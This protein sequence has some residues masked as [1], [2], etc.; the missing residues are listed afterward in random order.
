MP[1]SWASVDNRG[2]NCKGWRRLR[3]KRA[4]G[5]SLSH[6]FMGDV[7]STVAKPA[8]KWDL[9][10]CFQSSMEEILM[11]HIICLYDFTF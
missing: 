7:G 10:A 11:E 3:V 5:R 1:L 8:R 9:K 6:R 4:C 2:F